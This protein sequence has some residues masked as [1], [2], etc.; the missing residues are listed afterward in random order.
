MC[1]DWL[2]CWDSSSE[3][4]CCSHCCEVQKN[5][6]RSR[7]LAAG[8][9]CTQGGGGGGFYT[10]VWVTGRLICTTALSFWV[11]LLALQFSHIHMCTAQWETWTDRHHLYVAE[12]VLAVPCCCLMFM[13]YIFRHRGLLILKII[14][15]QA[16][17]N[18]E[19]ECVCM[20][21]V[22]VLHKLIILSKFVTEKERK[23][24]EE[25]NHRLHYSKVI[26]LFY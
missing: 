4:I 6:T 16:H 24:E 17:R 19:R 8:V 9:V 1:C 23:K 26:V 14:S 11:K 2:L 13:T 3:K 25:K 5:C 22:C 21:L 20:C 15:I 18:R 12:T 7:A 10:S